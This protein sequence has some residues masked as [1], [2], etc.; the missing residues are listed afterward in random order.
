MKRHKGSESLRV[1]E[2]G[3]KLVTYVKGLEDEYSLTLDKLSRRDGGMQ[4]SNPSSEENLEVGD[5]SLGL[6]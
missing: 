2:E 6:N 5:I 1:R 3:W 4:R